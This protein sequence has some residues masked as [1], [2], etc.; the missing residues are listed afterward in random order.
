MRVVQFRMETGKR[1]VGVVQDDTVLDLTSGRSSLRTVYDIFLEAERVGAKFN[2]LLADLIAVGGRDTQPYP[3][4]LEVRPNSTMP[5]LL[6]PFDHADM[7]RLMV[8][9]TG[10]THLGSMQSRNKMHADDLGKSEEPQTDSAKMFQMGIAGGKPESGRRGVSPEWF[11]KGNGTILKGYQHDLE[12]PAYA[13]DGGEEPE[14]A[15]CYI[16]SNRG[17]PHRIGF[18]IGNEW[19]DHATEK[20]NYLYLA[21]SKLRTCAIGPELHTEFEFDNVALSC[22]VRRD[23]KVIYTS[24]ELHSGESA[25]CHSLGNCEDHHF[26][27][28]AHRF[29]GDCHV[30]FLGTS[31]LSHSERDW[32]YQPGDEITIAC[33]ALG[34]PLKNTVIASEPEAADPVVVGWA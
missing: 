2:E 17:I 27:Y 16:V 6:S 7:H 28:A 3:P 34:A 14:I 24:G 32:T 19:S 29:P 23:G 33:S 15:A 4:F 5:Y 13:R 18:A 31:K 9:G 30:H 22:A 25:M 20:I 8:S 26:K 10:L 21:P 11:Y 12:I 1:H